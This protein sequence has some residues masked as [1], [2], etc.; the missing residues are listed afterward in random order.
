MTAADRV[1]RWSTAGA[2]LGVRRDASVQV[3][4]GMSAAFCV[5]SST[6]FGKIWTPRP[7]ASR[8]RIWANMTAVG[9]GMT[10]ASSV[11]TSP[12]ASMRSSS[13]CPSRYSLMRLA[14]RSATS[15]STSSGLI[16]PILRIGIS[17]TSSQSHYPQQT[18][19]SQ[20][21]PRMA[22]STH[23]MA[24]D[25]HASHST[26]R[27]LRCLAAHVI[28][29]R[30]PP[31]PPSEPRDA[32]MCRG[33]RVLGARECSRTGARRVGLDGPPDPADRRRAD[34]PQ[35]D[36]DARLGAAGRPGSRAGSV[37]ARPRHHGDHRGERGPRPEA[38]MGSQPMSRG[39]MVLLST[40]ARGP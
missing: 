10:R 21:Y 36:G 37:A 18:K 22:A 7:C 28:T 29:D 40:V 17:V 19:R 33:G 15:A 38:P 1:S 25:A 35:F 4:L 16:E 39:I 12:M 11:P 9:R 34:L 5:L 32:L 6:S 31:L 30:R 14:A 8:S 13:G 3:V 2:V 23:E 27:V 20:P 24:G 26:C